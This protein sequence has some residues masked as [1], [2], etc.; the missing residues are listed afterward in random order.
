MNAVS[1]YPRAPQDAF[2]RRGVRP[3]SRPFALRQLAETQPQLQPA[4]LRLS[5]M[6]SQYFTRVNCRVPQDTSDTS[7]ETHVG[8]ADVPDENFILCSCAVVS[9]AGGC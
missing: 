6:I 2:R 7:V 5:A 3:R 1:F 8:E 9:R 4:L